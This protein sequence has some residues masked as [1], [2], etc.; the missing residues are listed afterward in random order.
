MKKRK[1][2]LL[3][4]DDTK[5]NLILVEKLL[6]NEGYD[7][8]YANDG[9]EA[10]Q[11]VGKKRFDMILLDVMMPRMD[12]FEA[13]RRLKSKEQT[14]DIPVIFLTAVADIDGISKGFDVGGVDYIIKPVK[15]REL[16]ARIKTHLELKFLRERDVEQTQRDIVYTLGFVG[17]LRSKDTGK[18][19]ERVAEYAGL[20]A[21]L[22][23]MDSE[24]A[25]VVKLAAAMH[26]I[27]KVAIPD[28]ILNKPSQLSDEERAVMNKHTQWG[29]H[30][31]SRSKKPI[32]Q[33][34]AT[35]AYEHH[36]KW[37]GSGYPRGLKGEQIH[38]YGRIAALVDVFDALGTKR[39]YKEAWSLEDIY[40]AIRTE[41][42]KHFDPKLVDL[43]VDHYGD[44]LSIRERL[45]D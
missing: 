20:M 39:S 22:Y 6:A 31:F 16:K 29:Y 35:I 17:E 2:S 40:A 34:A 25:E 24:E 5:T 27:G 36:E 18:H 28:G 43:F 4:V 3:V 41:S 33:A 21:R 8:T 12:G 7:I 32:L 38:I 15:P 37:D 19:V 1:P 30:I 26:D 13:C 44:F 10:L 14:K 9:I 45:L 23:G 42:G 11:A